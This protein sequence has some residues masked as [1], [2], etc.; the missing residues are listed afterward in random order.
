MVSLLLNGMD[1]G[2]MLYLMDTH[3][4]NMAIAV[5]LSNPFDLDGDE[6]RFPSRKKFKT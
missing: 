3:H 1:I 5:N 2:L 6:D 4:D